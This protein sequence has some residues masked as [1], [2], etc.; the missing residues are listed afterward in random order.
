MAKP[1]SEQRFDNSSL[2]LN[3]MFGDDK[4]DH[5]LLRQTPMNKI[6]SE[7][8]NKWLDLHEIKDDK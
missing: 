1:L 4:G 5:Q 6:N 2:D 3:L 8:F 7:D